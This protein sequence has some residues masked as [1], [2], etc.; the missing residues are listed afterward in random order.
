MI[1]KRAGKRSAEKNE[2]EEFQF[3]VPPSRPCLPPPI[4]P[5]AIIERPG[6]ASMTGLHPECA[7]FLDTLARLD[8]P[9]DPRERYRFPTRDRRPLALASPA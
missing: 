1:G 2:A 9:A 5:G 8:I 6:H 3:V 4:P 7:T